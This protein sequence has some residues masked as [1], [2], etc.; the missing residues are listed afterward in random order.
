MHSYLPGQEAGNV[1][2]VLEAGFGDYCEDPVDIAARVAGWLQEESVLETMSQN[3]RKAGNPHAASDIVKDIGSETVTWMKMNERWKDDPIYK[4]VIEMGHTLVL[5]SYLKNGKFSNLEDVAA[6]AAAAAEERDPKA[7]KR[8]TLATAAGVGVGAAVGAVVAGP[9][10]PIGLVLGGAIIPA[11]PVGL[12]VGGTVSGLAANKIARR[13]AAA[14]TPQ[15]EEEVKE[16]EEKEQDEVAP[17]S[18]WFGWRAEANMS[19]PT[20]PTLMGEHRASWFAWKAKTGE[21]PESIVSTD[22]ESELVPEPV[23]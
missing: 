19:A 8:S 21:P 20:T 23:Q 4:P 18:R 16:G 6:Q 22:A 7:T 14:T 3:A 11:L 9:L 1:D 2:V 12:A 15:V 13:S 5:D 10:L 17:N